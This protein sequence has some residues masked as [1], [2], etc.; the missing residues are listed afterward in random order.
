MY[1]KKLVFLTQTAESISLSNVICHLNGFG[2]LTFEHFDRLF[3]VLESLIRGT[4]VAKCS[5]F[6]ARIF[7]LLRKSEIE[8]VIFDGIGDVADAEV[9]VA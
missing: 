9:D 3:F 8:L 5:N 2:Q 4:K 7:E 6:S 1:M